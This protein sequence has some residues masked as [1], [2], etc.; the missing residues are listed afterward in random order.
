M[1][2]T[3]TIDDYLLMRASQLTGILSQS[4]WAVNDLAMRT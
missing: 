4:L 1:K 2:I 3:L